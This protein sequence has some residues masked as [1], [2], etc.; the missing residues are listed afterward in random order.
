VAEL[1]WQNSTEAELGR[2]SQI[3]LNPNFGASLL[4]TSR[5]RQQTPYFAVYL[6]S[7]LN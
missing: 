7:W 1:F 5:D 4:K 6:N 2:T 3:R